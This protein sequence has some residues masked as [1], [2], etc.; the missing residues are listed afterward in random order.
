MSLK[1]TEKLEIYQTEIQSL[2]SELSEK[3]NEISDS[4]KSDILNLKNIVNAKIEDVQFQ[5][6]EVQKIPSS[7]EISLGAA[8]IIF[9][10]HYSYQ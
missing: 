6:R 8:F 3:M 2:T 9:C 1:S 4:S 10:I 5:M 7:P